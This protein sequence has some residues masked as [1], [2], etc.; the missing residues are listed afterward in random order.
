MLE[1]KSNIFCKKYKCNKS[2]L[3]IFISVLAKCFSFDV[4]VTLL[5]MFVKLVRIWSLFVRSLS[6][7]FFFLF[8]FSATI[9]GQ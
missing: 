8:L 7:A 2:T 1:T 6:V 5:H 9:R 3:N 4:V